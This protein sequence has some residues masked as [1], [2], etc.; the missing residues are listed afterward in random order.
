MICKN[1]K[2]KERMRKVGRSAA[3]VLDRLCELVKP[4][5][6]TWEIDEAGGEIMEELGVKSACKG[7][8]SGHRIFPSHTCLSVNEEVVHGIGIKECILQE[9]DVLS[10]DVCVKQDGFIGDNCRTVPV[11]E[12]TPE[13]ARLLRVTEQSLYLGLINALHKNRVGDISAGV[14]QHVRDQGFAIIT[15]FVGHGVGRT[16][17]EDPQIP[18]FGKAG[19]GPQLRKGM[20]I[21]VE[22]MVNTKNP[23]IRMA[24]DGWTALAEDKLPSA[25]FEHTL[26]VDVDTPEI[27]TLPPGYHHATKFLKEKLKQLDLEVELDF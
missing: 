3:E 14:Q 12:V 20:A 27:V 21:C 16:L 6:S 8:R 22:P 24:K 13:V 9:G 25:H 18:N 15:N 11:G 4:G 19:T 23:G 2:E 17:H 5:M 7:Y 1:F 10:V 26:L